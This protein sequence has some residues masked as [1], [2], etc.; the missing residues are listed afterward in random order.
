MSSPP[1]GPGIAARMSEYKTTPATAET[2]WPAPTAWTYSEAFGRDGRRFVY[3]RATNQVHVFEPLNVGAPAPPTPA[4]KQVSSPNC[5]PT[6][7][8]QV[9]IALV[10]HTM[11]GTLAG[12][13][14]W[15]TNP[16]SQVSAHYGV[17]LDGTIHQY[18]PLEGAAWANGVLEQGNHWPGPVNI[19][20]NL[21]SVSIETEDKNDVDQVVTAA[22]YASVLAAGRLAMSRYGSIKYLVGHD[23]ISPQSR[24]ACPGKRWRA[25]GGFGSLARELGL[26]PI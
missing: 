14:S 22:Q 11:G 16:A 13:D 5:W 10:L 20:P 3:L 15:F 23:Q 1:V 21:L 4:I 2:Y 6:R 9:P 19:N 8:G 7:S 24:P 26:S 18:V 25:G 12:T 17:A